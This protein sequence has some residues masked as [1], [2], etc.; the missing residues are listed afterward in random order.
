MTREATPEELNARVN[1]GQIKIADISAMID[2]RNARN[3]VIEIANVDSA[4]ESD[5]DRFYDY[6]IFLVA[7]AESAKTHAKLAANASARLANP[8][9]EELEKAKTTEP[10]PYNPSALQKRVNEL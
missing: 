5:I 6:F 2:N 1:N 3:F 8:E 9:A 7:T 4:T 10:V